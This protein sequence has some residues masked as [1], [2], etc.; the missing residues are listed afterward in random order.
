MKSPI[1]PTPNP[2]FQ[3]KQPYRQQYNNKIKH[4]TPRRRTDFPAF[5]IDLW[6]FSESWWFRYP[7]TK[8]GSVWNRLE[9]FT[10]MIVEPLFP[11]ESAGNGNGSQGYREGS[12]GRFTSLRLAVQGVRHDDETLSPS[13]WL[14]T[15]D[16]QFENTYRAL[17]RSTQK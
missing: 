5:I 1:H 11:C 3:I 15:F 17:S 4:G 6:F 10:R 14:S 7:D 16:F 9:T 12:F 8:S 13:W 2:T